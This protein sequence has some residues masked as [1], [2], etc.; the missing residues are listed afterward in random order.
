MAGPS[1][2]NAGQAGRQPERNSG[3]T[4][5]SMSFFSYRGGAL[6]AE[7]VALARIAEAVGT[8]AYVYSS[9]ALTGHYREFTTAFAGLPATVCYALKANDS[10]AVVATFA[11]LGAGADVV[12]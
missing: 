12:S 11:A 8:P 9:A 5:D 4:A 10:L 1:Q 2:G 6:H 7:E 3:G